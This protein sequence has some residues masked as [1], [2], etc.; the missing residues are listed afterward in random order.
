MRKRNS[1]RISRKISKR[2]SRKRINNNRKMEKKDYT[3]NITF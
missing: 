2:I 3:E 1:K